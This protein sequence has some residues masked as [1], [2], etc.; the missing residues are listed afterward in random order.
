MLDVKARSRL[1]KHYGD[2]RESIPDDSV[3]DL[4]INAMTI[5]GCM[6]FIGGILIFMVMYG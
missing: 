4:I 6:T 5:L 3:I 2:Q 1:A